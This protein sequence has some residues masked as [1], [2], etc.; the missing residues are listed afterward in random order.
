M[1]QWLRFINPVDTII[2]P[3]QKKEDIYDCLIVLSII[4]PNGVS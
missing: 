3:K 1:D 4:V 2:C